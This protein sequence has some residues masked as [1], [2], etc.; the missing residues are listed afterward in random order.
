MKIDPHH[1]AEAYIAV[2]VVDHYLVGAVSPTYSQAITLEEYEATR[3][4]LITLDNAVS[5]QSRT[6]SRAL[7][8]IER[9]IR[10]AERG[11]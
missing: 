4:I 9:D 2:A 5:N 8:M 10:E 7:D 1:L 11:A 6:I 3:Q